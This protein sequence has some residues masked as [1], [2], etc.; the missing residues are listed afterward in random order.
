ML[1]LQEAWF[2][3]GCMFFLDE[4]PWNYLLLL[5]TSVIV[6]SLR[7]ARTST[8]SCHIDEKF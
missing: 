1:P 4:L 5:G 6:P 2:S 3:L 7:V 8:S